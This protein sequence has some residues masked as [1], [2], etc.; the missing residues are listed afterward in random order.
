MKYAM[1]SLRFSLS[2]E[3]AP[4][5][6]QLMEQICRGIDSGELVVGD[7]LPSSRFL[8]SS[9]G[10]SRSTTS[11]A[12]EQLV[13]EGI[14]TSQEKRGVF[15]AA[16]PM[17]NSR[18]PKRVVVDT[19]QACVNTE[20]LAFDSGV[21]VSVFPS[22]EWATSM[23]RS[24]LSPDLTLL[25]G[26][27]TTGYPGLKAQIVAYLYRV[28]GLECT[29]EQIIVTAGSRDS[30]L[31]LQRTFASLSHH[32]MT[33]WVEEPTYPPIREALG[34]YVRQG[35]LMIDDDGACVPTATVCSNAAILTPNRQYPLGMA[36][37]SQRR[38]AWLHAVQD[39]ASD[40]WL[41]EDDYDNEFVYQGQS[42][43]PFMQSASV[44]DRAKDRVF[45]MGSFSKVLF[46]GLRLGFIVAPMKHVAA[47]QHS[48]HV[49]GVSASLPIQPV[50]AD[51]MEQGHFD[52]HV[53]RMRRHYRLKREALLTL[54]EA[55]LS[56][57]FE[58]RKPRG[59]M[60]VL[61]EIKAEMVAKC[62]VN[63]LCLDQ[64]I[65]KELLIS[66][67][68]L[69]YLSS[70]Y[71]PPKIAGYRMGFILGFSGPDEKAMSQMVRALRT[72]WVKNGPH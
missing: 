15:V 65:A 26:G 34:S 33:W 58:W 63:S 52:R 28:R 68:R 2:E 54:L 59:G 31:L 6:Q 39:D 21:D 17:L 12:Y 24:W 46:R 61:I 57:W 3:G 9:L 27:Y 4:Y 30:L 37:S 13:A 19:R 11:R 35:A 43:V 16:L 56:P 23:R 32:D 67:I 40:W 70:H 14:L 71:V 51:F 38:Q 53:N 69:S 41:I 1:G 22:K 72:W 60:H 49:I 20:L 62:P 47:L 44:Y 66:N 5:Y 10:V 36:M 64:Q 42:N 50:V 25:Q 55:H 45:F 8:A 7:K 29:A 48:Q 18:A